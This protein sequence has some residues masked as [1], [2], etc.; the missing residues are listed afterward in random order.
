MCFFFLLT[1]NDS[2]SEIISLE[3]F[4]AERRLAMVRVSNV[5]ARQKLQYPHFLTVADVLLFFLGEFKSSHE[6]RTRLRVES[7]NIGRFSRGARR[8]A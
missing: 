1:K 7:A 8:N 4:F 5:S 6:G 2:L 3:A